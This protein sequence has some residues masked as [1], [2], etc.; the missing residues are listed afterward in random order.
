MERSY[1]DNY[2]RNQKPPPITVNDEEEY[3]IEQILDKRTRYGKTQYF[4]KW[5]G[6]PFSEASLELEEYLN[7]P[8]LF[9][10]FNKN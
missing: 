4:I 9:E 2:G 3:E 5:K 10:E 1:E 6:F 7:C 8:K